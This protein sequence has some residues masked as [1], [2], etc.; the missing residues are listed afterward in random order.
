MKMCSSCGT[1][2]ED[3]EFFSVA[4]SRSGGVPK[5]VADCKPCYSDRMKRSRGKNW[6]RGS[7]RSAVQ[8]AKDRT[9]HHGLPF[10]VTINDCWQLRARQRNKCVLSGLEFEKSETGV[11]RMLSPSLDR[12]EPS[13]GYVAGNIRFILHALNA[14]K[15]SGTDVELIVICRAVLER[16]GA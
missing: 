5:L 3:T 12:I 8:S 4:T 16:A 13:K 6:L 1:V 11:A 7:V 15:G 14:M 2:K 10:S 9:T